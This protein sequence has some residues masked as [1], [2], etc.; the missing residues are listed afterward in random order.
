MKSSIALETFNRLWRIASEITAIHETEV[1]I[2]AFIDLPRRGVDSLGLRLSHLGLELHN[3][4]SEKRKLLEKTWEKEVGLFES[5]IRFYDVNCNDIASIAN[6]LKTISNELKSI[7]NILSVIS[8]ICTSLKLELNQRSNEF[9]YVLLVYYRA[10]EARYLKQ[11]EILNQ[12]YD[13]LR[14]LLEVIFK[15]ECEEYVKYVLR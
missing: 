4:L 9:I 2:R 13:R 7:E 3:Q 14:K 11:K 6:E 10:I 12:K 15:P 5:I 8:K 1:K